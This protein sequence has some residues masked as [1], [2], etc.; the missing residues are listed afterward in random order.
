MCID[1][2]RKSAEKRAQHAARGARAAALPRRGLA[3]LGPHRASGRG[4][5]GA[6]RA[7]PAG[8][9][10]GAALADARAP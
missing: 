6:A 4:P 2:L 3:R 7:A 10:R 8:Q 9:R 1:D 5:A